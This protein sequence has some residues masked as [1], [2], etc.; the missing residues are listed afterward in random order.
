MPRHPSEYGALLGRLIDKHGVSCWLV[1][2]GWTG[3]PHGQGKRMPIKETRALLT[4]AL[5]GSLN[6]AP[7]RKDAV[8]G[9]E[10]PTEVAGVDKR[11]LHPRQTWEDPKAFDAQ[12]QKLAGMF[13]ENFRIFEAHVGD[14]V[15]AAGPKA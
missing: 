13:V 4:A 3:G 8:F 7:M 1:S 2:T 14:D 12:A 10:V 9:F 11:I 6:A 15:K 5:N